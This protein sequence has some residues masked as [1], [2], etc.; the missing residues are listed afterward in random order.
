MIVDVTLLLFLLAKDY[1]PVELSWYHGNEKLEAKDCSGPYGSCLKVILPSVT[2]ESSGNLY[3]CRG[4]KLKET[5]WATVQI[6]VNGKSIEE[7]FK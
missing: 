4:T 1:N 3:T 7:K 5:F 2:L 6:Y